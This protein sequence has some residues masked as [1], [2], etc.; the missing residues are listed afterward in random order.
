MLNFWGFQFLALRNPFFMPK[1]IFHSYA[2]ATSATVLMQ[3][4]AHEHKIQVTSERIEVKQQKLTDIFVEKKKDDSRKIAD[5]KFIFSRRLLVWLCR[6]LLPFNLV[7]K[8]GFINFLNSL[9]RK[10]TDVP[11]RITISNMALDDMY[12]CVKRKLISYLKETDGT[13]VGRLQINYV[14][15]LLWIF[16]H[17]I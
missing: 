7:E 12:L 4:V 17:Q 11:S 10:R 1:Q 16:R 13:Y 2:N 8:E 6:D 3:H 5:D 9:N 14:K 15:S